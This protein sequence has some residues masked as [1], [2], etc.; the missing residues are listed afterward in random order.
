[1]RYLNYPLALDAVVASLFTCIEVGVCPEYTWSSIDLYSAELYNLSELV[2][3]VT[4]DSSVA[5][6]LKLQ[7]LG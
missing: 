5:L 3:T 7:W 1:M 6:H 4:S 2:L